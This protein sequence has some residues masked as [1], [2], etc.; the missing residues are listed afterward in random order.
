MLC[1]AFTNKGF[2]LTLRLPLCN[3][4]ATQKVITADGWLKTGDLG[5]LD[6]EGFLY[7]KDR[8]KHSSGA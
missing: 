2:Q 1:L 5:Y 7:I 3:L 6:E 4:E 8:S